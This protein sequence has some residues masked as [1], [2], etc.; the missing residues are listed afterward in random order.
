VLEPPLV[1]P[2]SRAA[3]APGRVVTFMPFA[4]DYNLG[5]A[6]NEAMGLLGED[7]W[8]VFLDHDAIWTTREWYRQ[9][10]AVTRAVPD[11]G[12]VTAVQSRG[13]QSWQVGP[14]QGHDMA[15]NRRIGAQL[16]RNNTLLDVTETSGIAGVVM[17]VSKRAWRAVGG[18]TDGMYCVDHAFHFALRA[19]GLRV[20]VHEGLYVYHWRRAN[21]DAPPRQAPRAPGCP[22]ADIRLS[23]VP[24][25][26]RVQLP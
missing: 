23:E 9:L 2:P 15:E 7:D 25:T 21:G 5:G 13:W 10:E 18:Y 16:L 26:R 14:Y 22:C 17:L 24:P 12:C 20:Y 11:A 8:A 6:Y 4:L 3:L 19:A 1:I